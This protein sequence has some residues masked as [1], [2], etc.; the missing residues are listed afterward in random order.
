MTAQG[1]PRAI[2]KR[3]IERGNVLVAEAKAGEIGLI[4]SEPP[5]SG[6]SRPITLWSD[7]AARRYSDDE[8]M[9]ISKRWT[10]A[11]VASL[12]CVAAATAAAVTTLPATAASCPP[13]PTPLQPFLPWGDN[14]DYVLTT[15]GSFE[16]GTPSWALSGSAKTVSDNAPNQFDPQTDS[17]ALFLPSGSSAT[18]ACVTAPQI[19]GI[20]RFFA[21]NTGS[22]DAA[23]KVEI[24]V[25]GKTYLAGTIT[26][27][28]TWAPTD[29]LPSNAP[30]YKGAVTYQVRLTALGTGAAFTLD[31]TY[32]DPYKSG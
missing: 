23:L 16:P 2:F 29:I 9:T 26:A 1:H 17:H 19:Q 5:Q 10:F 22:A 18:S 30:H 27:G 8:T 14:G 24:I 32:F 11:V 13:P 21:K 20:V 7:S 12:C 3:A 28:S 25:K 31:D 15:G 4:S 6:D